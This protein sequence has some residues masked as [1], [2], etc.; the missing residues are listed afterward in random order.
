MNNDATTC[1]SVLP[2]YQTERTAENTAAPSRGILLLNSVLEGGAIPS[3]TE[4]INLPKNA[5]KQ[6]RAQLASVI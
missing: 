3:T 5:W 2:V 1:E 6:L 4:N